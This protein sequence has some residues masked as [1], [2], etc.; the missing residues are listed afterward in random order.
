MTTETVSPYPAVV[1][2][3]GNPAARASLIVGIVIVVLSVAQVV[4]SNF[5]PLIMRGT[6]FD[7]GMVG[8]M[9]GII[10][11]VVGVLAVIGLILGLV[12]LGRPTARAAAGAG[13]AIAASSLLTV[14]IGFL[15]PSIIN[16]IY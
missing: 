15:M 1:P 5:L 9:F 3:S 14:V 13:T 8:T 10:A 12:G 4:I 7:S 11:A 6:G 16:A 2:S